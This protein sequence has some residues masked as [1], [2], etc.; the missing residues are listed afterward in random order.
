M[1]QRRPAEATSG[2]SDAIDVVPASSARPA[3]GDTVGGYRLVR[4]LGAGDTGEVFLGVATTGPDGA[5]REAVAVKVL[6]PL[7]PDELLA[8]EVEALA[9]LEHPH[10]ERLLDVALDPTGRPC[11]ILERLTGG[12]LSSLLGSGRPPS[13]GEAVTV[14]API[15]SALDAMH[16]AGV[17]HTAIRLRSIR[18]RDSG[19]PVLRGFGRASLVTPDE[20]PARLALLPGVLTDRSD[21]ASVVSAV[22]EGAGVALPGPE[23]DVEADAFGERLAERLFDLAEPRPVHLQRSRAA[24]EAEVPSRASVRTA[25]VPRSRPPRP[26][27]TTGMTDGPRPRR[28]HVASTEAVAPPASTS[29]RSSRSAGRSTGE[30]ERVTVGELLGRGAAVVWEHARGVRRRYWVVAATV[31]TTLV[32]AVA[33]VPS[34]DGRTADGAGGGGPSADGPGGDD[35]APTPSSR[36]GGLQPA[37]EESTTHPSPGDGPGAS[38]PEAEPGPDADGGTTTDGTD[39]PTRSDDP[40]VALPAL[41]EQR[42]RCV[43]DLSVLCLDLVD[44]PGSAALLRDTELVRSVQEG[45]E[46]PDGAAVVLGTPT[47]VERLGDSALVDLGAGPHSTTAS[48]LMMRGEAGWRIRDYLGR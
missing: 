19:A 48:T 8:R 9:R 29:A 5:G 39:D 20:P 43:R 22:L 12:S 6:H 32:V 2:G 24:G 47:L 18:F 45:G 46:L 23:L 34:G 7:A 10:L 36:G 1:V 37:T 13:A 33:V 27:V 26:P 3:P 16:A 4:R 11:L 44:Q 42:D 35:G 31:V 25:A 14:L 21:L 30:R 41:L 38:A 17:V 28:R 15:A 40:L